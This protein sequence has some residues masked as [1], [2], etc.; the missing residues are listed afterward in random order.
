MVSESQLVKRFAELSTSQQSVETLSLFFMHHRRQSQTIVHVWAKELVSASPD[1][2]IAFLYVAND[3]IQHDKRK[4]GEFVKDF[5][6]ILPSAIQHIV[7]QL[8]DEN[9]HKT[10]RRIINIWGERQIYQPDAIKLLKTSFE[11]GIDKKISDDEDDEEQTNGNGKRKLNDPSSS[12]SNSKR[13]RK[14][15]RKLSLREEIRRDLA[16]NPIPVPVVDELVKML[17]ELEN[18]PSSDADV[19]EKIAALPIEVSDSNLLKNLR[20]K[21]EA[22]DLYKLVQMAHGLLDEYNLRLESELR[23]RR[24]TAKIL[25]GY[26]QAQERQIEYEEKNLEEHKSKLVKL[27]T[28][29]EEIEK[30]RKNMPQDVNNIDMAPLPSAGDLFA[31]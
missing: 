9:I 29:G 2:K 14:A 12:G 4:G 8:N 26:I 13:R 10:V 6:P 20:D 22:T 5:L 11:S 25:Q 21:Q 17:Q 28:I 3:V 18:S 23:S 24:H 30:H 19:R 27:Q 16:I 7:S 31:R 1:K 15:K